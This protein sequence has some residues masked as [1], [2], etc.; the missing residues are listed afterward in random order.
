MLVFAHGDSR[1]S[2]VQLQLPLE[3]VW[4]EDLEDLDPQTSMESG[5]REREGG[6]VLVMGKYCRASRQAGRQ[7]D[8]H[9]APR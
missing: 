4:V 6:I 9:L 5:M 7:T 3:A 2:K 1:Q 8:R